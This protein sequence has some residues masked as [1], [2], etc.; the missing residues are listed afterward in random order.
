MGDEQEI[1]QSYLRKEILEKNYDT[2]S[3]L[4]FL[5]SKKGE[6]VP[7]K[8]MIKNEKQIEGI[9]IA[10]EI[11]SKILDKVLAQYNSNSIYNVLW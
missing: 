2:Q 10:S 9:K 4:D 6:K 3:F 8:S 5:I 1:K 7:T 11:N